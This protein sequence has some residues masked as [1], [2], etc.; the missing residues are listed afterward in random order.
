[1]SQNTD[2][3]TLSKPIIE[4]VTVANEFCYY[5]GTADD[6]SKKGILEFVHRIT[7]LLYLKGSLLPDI[8]PEYPEANERFVTQENWETI[9]TVLREKFGKDDEYW[10]LDPQYINDTEPLKASISENLAD[11]YQDMK[12]FIMLFQKN[13]H[14]ARENAIS[15]FKTLFGNHWGYSIGNILTRIHHL[16]QEEN[17]ETP[18]NS[19]PLGF[20]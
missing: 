2:D 17:E 4:M 6:K 19:D 11:I 14:A 7:P 9:F 1:M 10:I 12:D 5:I 18:K 8:E 16:L 13:T 15:D 20:F 3:I